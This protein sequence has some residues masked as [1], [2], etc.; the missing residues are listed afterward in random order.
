[1]H[2]IMYRKLKKLMILTGLVVGISVTGTGEAI[3]YCPRPVRTPIVVS[4]NECGYSYSRS[5][6]SWSS[7]LNMYGAYLYT[8]TPNVAIEKYWNSFEVCSECGKK[9]WKV[10]TDFK[11]WRED[12]SKDFT[13]IN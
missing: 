11:K 4:C 3:M 9:N 1:M 13:T 5:F 6:S 8:M 12:T 10:E 2:R 7:L